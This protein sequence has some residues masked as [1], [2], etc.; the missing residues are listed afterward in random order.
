MLMVYGS[1]VNL[2]SYDG[3]YVEVVCEV[4]F[5]LVGQQCVFGFEYL[6]VFVIYG[7]F[8]DIEV[9]VGYWVQVCVFYE[10]VLV[11]CDKVLGVDDVFI[12]EIVGCLYEVFDQLYDVFVVLVVCQCYFD[13]FV[14][15]D[16]VI[17]NVSLKDVCCFV[18]E[19][20]Y[21]GKV[22]LMF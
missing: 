22:L 8:G 3:Q 6:I 14:V 21:M 18:L 17:F 13:F 20:L 15:K 10:K 7:L 12:L 4:W 2:F 9:D 1:L 19:V 16:L 11:G 5:I